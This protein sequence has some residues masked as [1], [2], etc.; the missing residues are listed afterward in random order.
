MGRNAGIGD[1][2]KMREFLHDCIS[3]LR[4]IRGEV[5]SE[6]C[7]WFE[8]ILEVRKQMSCVKLENEQDLLLRSIA[9]SPGVFGTCFE[10]RKSL[11][12]TAVLILS[13]AG[14]GRQGVGAGLVVSPG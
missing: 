5:N 13:G 2:G 9:D 3:L 8:G 4:E 7:S 11:V 12:S 10:L 6:I 14:S 1:A